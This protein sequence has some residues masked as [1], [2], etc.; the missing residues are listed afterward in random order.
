VVG[1]GLFCFRHV[2]VVP[3]DGSDSSPWV[4]VD[5]RSESNLKADGEKGVHTPW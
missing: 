2:T 4:F 5:A 3:V 1:V